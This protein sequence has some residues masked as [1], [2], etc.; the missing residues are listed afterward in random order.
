RLLGWGLPMYPLS[1]PNPDTKRQRPAKLS[2]AGPA[3][4]LK[5]CLGQR[6]SVSA[7]SVRRDHV[8]P[9][10]SEGISL[11]RH[12]I[13]VADAVIFHRCRLKDHTKPLPQFPQGPACLA[14]GGSRPED[15]R[16]KEFGQ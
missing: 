3:L 8:E 1:R 10:G 14:A 5:L 4:R 12:L 7:P 11:K 15:G 2:P 6:L 13:H 9:C 16:V